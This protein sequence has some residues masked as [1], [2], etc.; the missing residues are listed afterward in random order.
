MIV[1]LRLE[2]RAGREGLVRTC[3][4]GMNSASAADAEDAAVAAAA[5]LTTACQDTT[6]RA[7][8][9]KEVC[10]HNSYRPDLRQ[11]LEKRAGLPR[12]LC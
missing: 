9:R 2:S 1:R 5:H 10:P 3:P 6:C 4:C 12:A 11:A 7:G 8:V